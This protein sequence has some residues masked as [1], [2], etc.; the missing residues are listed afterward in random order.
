LVIFDLQTLAAT[1]GLL[2]HRTALH[3]VIRLQHRGAAS[4]PPPLPL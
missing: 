1:F 2:G 4:P 3:Y